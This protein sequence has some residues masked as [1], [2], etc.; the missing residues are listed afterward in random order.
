[1]RTYTQVSGGIVGRVKDVA[2]LYK[3][4]TRNVGES[5]EMTKTQIGASA[6]CYSKY[7]A[8]PL[9]D[10]DVLVIGVGQ[11][12]REVM[13]FGMQN[14]VVGI[15]LD[16]IPQGWRPGQYVRLLRQNGGMRFAKTV[17]RKL[18]GIDRNLSRQ[19]AL[20]F[21]MTKKPTVQIL[22]MN[23]TDMRLASNTFD[24]VYSFSVFEHLDDPKAVLSKAIR[25][26]KPG[27]VVQ[28]STHIYSSEGGC[29]DLRIFAGDRDSIPLWAHL[30]PSVK[31]TVL[32][33][34]YMNMWR[35]AQWRELFAEL[36]PGGEVSFD[37]HAEPR[38]TEFAKALVELRKAG[39]LGEY[40]DQELLMVNLVTTWQ[41]PAISA[42]GS[43]SVLTVKSELH[44]A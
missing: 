11:T 15:D 17:G 16:V 10:R 18:L 44:V 29:H 23:A 25:V 14:R 12:L 34:C 8:A 38:G 1:M 30:R 13:G 33:S 32:E 19:L 36:C 22:Q 9:V 3:V 37:K 2:R 7:T 27:G 26:L 31:N 28:I 40:S 21:G 39:E 35:D 24:F 43:T 20:G 6:D 41:K 5:I 4:R 42:T